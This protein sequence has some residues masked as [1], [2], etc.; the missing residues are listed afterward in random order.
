MSERPTD[1]MHV[2]DWGS[3]PLRN[4]FFGIGF[5]NFWGFPERGPLGRRGEGTL[6]EQ[7]RKA[8]ARARGPVGAQNWFSRFSLT[9]EFCT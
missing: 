2:Q 4:V 5:R 6:V 9:F 7:K 3:A 1:R 8:R